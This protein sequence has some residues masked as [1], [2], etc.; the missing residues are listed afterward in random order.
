MNSVNKKNSFDRQTGV[1][2]ISVMLLLAMLVALIAYMLESQYL[3]IRQSTLVSKDEASYLLN[4]HAEAWA[5]NQLLKKRSAS[6]RKPYE[7]D[8]L[9]ESWS[10]EK[11]EEDKGFIN[12]SAR[13][14]DLQGRFNINNLE[15][16][17]L[18][19][20]PGTNTGQSCES[21]KACF[22]NL[23]IKV[24]AANDS[25][26]SQREATDIT[27]SIISW[28]DPVNQVS[29]GRLGSRDYSFKNPPYRK[30]NRRMQSTAELLQVA[31]MTPEIYTALL[32]HIAVIDAN[33]V[34]I[35]VHTATRQ[36][37]EAI[38]HSD[39]SP[40]I[41]NQFIQDRQD[42]FEDMQEAELHDALSGITTVIIDVKSSYFEMQNGI[43]FYDPKKSSKSEDESENES[44]EDESEENKFKKQF[45]ISTMRFRSGIKRMIDPN[46]NKVKLSVIYRKRGV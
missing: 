1:A 34:K 12:S 30:A 17:P 19:P 32:P 37:L 24:T 29:V 46:T 15:S 25:P 21:W 31:G 22:V 28:I 10:E 38:V 44:E 40:I 39:V 2:L 27:D 43:N 3:V 11:F 45:E 18:N 5:T 7:T 41:L 4:T 26:L 9:A 42:G 36:V 20:N 8:F 6:N 16:K 35:N 13:L 33:D 14:I 23:L